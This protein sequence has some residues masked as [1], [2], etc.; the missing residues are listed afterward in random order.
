MKRFAAYLLAAAFVV[1]ARPASAQCTN[2]EGVR[3]S[4]ITVVRGGPFVSISGRTVRTTCPAI[5]FDTRAQTAADGMMCPLEPAENPTVAGSTKM[6]LHL[7]GVYT[8]SSNG[9]AGIT[10]TTHWADINDGNGGI[11]CVDGA[12]AG[13]PAFVPGPRTGFNT[14]YAGSPSTNK[15]GGTMDI[16]Y[17]NSVLSLKDK[18]FTLEMWIRRVYPASASIA[19]ERVLFKDAPGNNGG[20]RDCVQMSVQAGK[21]VFRIDCTGNDQEAALQ[22]DTAQGTQTNLDDG[23]WHYVVFKYD[24]VSKQQAIFIDGTIDSTRG[25]GDHY[26]GDGGS[27]ISINRDTCGPDNTG[28]ASGFDVDDIR[29][30]HSAFGGDRVRSRYLG[31]NFFFEAS[32]GVDRGTAFPTGAF[33]NCTNNTNNWI[34]YTAAA[35]QGSHRQFA[36]TGTNA[37]HV[38]SFTTKENLCDT[39]ITVSVNQDVLDTPPT[40]AISTGTMQRSDDHITW[41]WNSYNS[42]VDPAPTASPNYSWVGDDDGGGRTFYNITFDEASAGAQTSKYFTRTG[43]NPNSQHCMR[44]TAETRDTSGVDAHGINATCSG[45]TVVSVETPNSC[46][47]TYAV[48]PNAP[49]VGAAVSGTAVTVTVD[50]GTNDAPTLVNIEGT[51]DAG[52]TWSQVAP[53]SQHNGVAPLNNVRVVADLQKSKRYSF[54]S[55]AQ[56]WD[57]F[58]TDPSGTSAA[59]YVTQPQ[60]PAGFTG[61]PGPAPALCPKTSLRWSWTSMVV[62]SGASTVYQVRNTATDTLICSATAP[63]TSCDQTGI[64]ATDDGTPVSA[65]IRA[66]DTG[67]TFPFSDTSSTVTVRTASA[68]IPQVAGLVGTPITPGVQ[69]DWTA[70]AALCSAWTY[71]IHF[72]NTPT[73]P[74]DLTGSPT[75]QYVQVPL[76]TNAKSVIRVQAFDSI[77]TIALGGSALS[78]SATM[79]SNANPPASLSVTAVTTTT[80]AISWSANGN[81]GY[82]RYTVGIS[83]NGGVTISSRVVLG[84]NKT[85]TTYTL[86]GLTPGRS[87]FITVQAFNGANGEPYAYPTATINATAVTQTLAPVVSGTPDSTSQVTFFW[88]AVPNAA[89]YRV[90]DATT[91]GQLGPI[92]GAGGP[93]TYAYG[94]AAPNTL[95]G[96]YVCAYNSS[97]L[98]SCSDRAYVYTNPDPAGPAN[99]VTSSSTTVTVG[100][101]AGGNPNPG[102][103]WEVNIATGQLFGVV[104]ATRSSLSLSLTI[105]DLF[106]ATTYYARVRAYSASGGVSAFQNV[107]ISTATRPSSAVYVS[108]SPSSVYVQAGALTGL[109]HFDDAIS[110]KTSDSSDYGNGAYVACVQNGCASTPTFTGGMPTLSTAIA[111][112]GQTNSLVFVPHRAQYNGGAMTVAVWAKPATTAL[113]NNTGLVTKGL[114]GATDFALE[115]VNGRFRFSAGGAAVDSASSIQAQQWQRVVGIYEPAN[116]RVRIAVNGTIE[117]TTAGVAARTNNAEPIAIGNRKGVSGQYSHGFIGEL[118]ELALRAEA[119]AAADVTNDYTGSFSSTLTLTGIGISGGLQLYLPPNAF[120]QPAHIYASRDPINHPL[121]I[122]LATLSNGLAAAPTGQIL[123]PDSLVEIVPSVRGVPFSTTLGSSATITMPYVDADNDGLLDGLTP[124]VAVHTLKMYTLDSSVVR[125]DALPTTIDRQ[126]KTIT[127]YTTHF[128]VFAIFGANTIGTTLSEIKIYPNPWQRGSKTRYDAPALT[129]DN[130]PQSG[131]IRI[132]TLSGEPVVDLAFS[133]VNAGTLTWNGRNY[134][135]R[136]VASGV[137]FAYIKGDGSTRFAKFA[138][139]R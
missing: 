10:V 101:N 96:V 119:W 109:W 81:P 13:V 30:T 65:Y 2:P 134:H 120:G 70:P 131:T 99:W 28:F 85:S 72:Q 112:A 75:P 64:G 128:S 18:S 5:K 138:I 71:R 121:S 87:Y 129:F 123:I 44:M 127:G 116:N 98:P 62:G 94:G 38:R 27:C 56:N 50:R 124:P 111:F 12:A 79:Y 100:W 59:S 133:G 17:T 54:R 21:A 1:L 58:I 74:L 92:V 108:P 66:Q 55:R 63:A 49:V 32:G 97:G 20:T 126:S 3:F 52:A 110:S 67:A 4:S 130:L 39:D 73:A 105:G 22:T 23:S 103:V 136:E 135:G 118:D 113:A 37:F 43:L 91:N 48:V 35:G 90:F 45:S 25:T 69:W 46:G 53:Y 125:W 78:D 93:F 114:W 137:Y 14:G 36:T 42:A 11:D 88:S 24:A 16:G 117:A 61:G 26:K 57:G 77:D 19:T 31:A 7:D 107:P 122:D 41:H 60:T 84:D 33:P 80:I 132:L 83:E 104:V 34:T 102:T 6:L 76:G 68:Q 47:Y 8:D 51:T 95:L 139:E 15:C 29:L 115:I 9:G 86:T 89:T 40:P 82:T 106:P